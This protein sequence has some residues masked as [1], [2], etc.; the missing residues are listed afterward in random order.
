MPRNQITTA[1]TVRRSLGVPS[2][3]GEESYQQASYLS[4]LSNRDKELHQVTARAAGNLLMRAN[5]AR[6][7]GDKEGA[8]KLQQRMSVLLANYNKAHPAAPVTAPEIR[9]IVFQMTNPELYQRSKMPKPLLP[10]VAASPYR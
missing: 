2:L 7:S 6:D 10:E 9:N 8:L 1:D 5:E 3:A 4:R